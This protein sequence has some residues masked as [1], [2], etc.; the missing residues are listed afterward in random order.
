MTLTVLTKVCVAATMI[1]FT[2]LP[3]FADG[4]EAT[5][6]VLNH[7][8]ESFGTANMDEFLADYTDESVIIFN[9]IKAVGAEGMRPIAQALFDEFG[10]PGMTFEMLQMQVDGRVAYIVWTAETADNVYEVA[11]DTFVVE[12]GKIMYQTIAG[13]ITPKE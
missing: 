6:A 1:G 5:Q 8:L 13:K 12:N 10:K 3:A 4:T 9:D 7:H 2:A 11:T